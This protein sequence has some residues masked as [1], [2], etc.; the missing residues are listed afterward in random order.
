MGRITTTLSLP[1]AGSTRSGDSGSHWI[2]FVLHFGQSADEEK[3]MGAATAHKHPKLLLVL[4]AQ[5]CLHYVHAW[6]SL[7][8]DPSA[9][10]RSRTQ[11]RASD[12]PGVP[13]GSGCLGFGEDCIWSRSDCSAG[14]GSHRLLQWTHQQ[15]S[16]HYK[17]DV[18]TSF[19]KTWLSPNT[20]RVNNV[21]L[22]TCWSE[23]IHS[24]SADVHS[25]KRAL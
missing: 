9:N 24:V 16:D 10:Q 23:S 14:T 22:L 3:A 6:G 7:E 2:C 13:A 15:V 25:A 19:Q 11:C 21:G 17:S 5:L 12:C 20:C 1:S 18:H 4:C 8:A